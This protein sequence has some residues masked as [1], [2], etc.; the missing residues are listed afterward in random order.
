MVA[1]HLKEP[2]RTIRTSVELLREEPHSETGK[3]IPAATDRILGGASRLEEIAA[4]V[5]QYADDLSDE[6]E[7]MKRVNTEAVLRAVRQKLRPLMEQTQAG[8]TSGPLPELECQ[9]TRFARLVE[10][11]VKNAILYRRE[12]IPPAVHVSANKQ[13]TEWL[14]SIADNGTG[15]EPAYLDQ[16][17]EPFRRMHLNERRGL[18]MGLTTCRQIVTRHGGRIWMESIPG[19]GS[20]V[21]FTLPA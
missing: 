17:F 19:V 21:F 5:A 3:D 1:H 20:V 18:G 16:I 2:V 14:F 9:P 7:P 8:V 11:L 12:Q 15:V 4:S 13:P 6:D 10:H